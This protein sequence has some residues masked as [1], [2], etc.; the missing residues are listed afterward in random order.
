MSVKQ[1]GQLK[2]KN[3]QFLR[4]SAKAVQGITRQQCPYIFQTNALEE[5]ICSTN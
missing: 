3:L 5:K 4:E 1:N 2:K